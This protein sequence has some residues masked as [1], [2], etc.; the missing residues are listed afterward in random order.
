MRINDQLLSKSKREIVEREK[1]E[2]LVGARG[3]LV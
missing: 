2:S 1:M 3:Q